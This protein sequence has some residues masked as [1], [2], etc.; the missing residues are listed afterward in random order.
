M[1]NIWIKIGRTSTCV[2]SSKLRRPLSQSLA[3]LLRDNYTHNYV[4][5]N[6][7]HGNWGVLPLCP[8]SKETTSISIYIYTSIYHLVCSEPTQVTDRLR[9]GQCYPP[10]SV[11]TEQT[12]RSC[13]PLN[14]SVLR[15]SDLPMDFE[16]SMCPAGHKPSQVANGMVA[17]APHSQDQLTANKNILEMVGF[18]LCNWVLAI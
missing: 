14:Q 4:L 8:I 17:H 5:K 2:P 6:L 15:P 16:T 7:H 12:G 3:I 9:L 1:V 18:A 11:P 10:G 13:W